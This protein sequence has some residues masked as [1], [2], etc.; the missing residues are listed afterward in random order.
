MLI[1][2]YSPTFKIFIYVKTKIYE[3][4]MYLFILA[5]KNIFIF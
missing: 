3:N 4:I 2:S 5:A 1:R